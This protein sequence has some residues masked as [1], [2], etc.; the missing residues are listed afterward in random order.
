MVNLEKAKQFN[1]K[2]TLI[3]YDASGELRLNSCTGNYVKKQI[4]GRARRLYEPDSFSSPG[5]VLDSIVPL[6]DEMIKEAKEIK[7]DKIHHYPTGVNVYA[8]CKCGCRWWV[9]ATAA[10]TSET[11]RIACR[12][13]KGRGLINWQDVIK[14]SELQ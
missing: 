4:R 7:L 13:C 6:I 9:N 1:I 2:P 5:I 10:L 14:S 11:V 3:Y 8:K 12:N